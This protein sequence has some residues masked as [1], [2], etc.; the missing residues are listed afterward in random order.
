MENPTA[1][2]EI[3]NSAIKFV[4][5]YVID[6]KASIIYKKSIP[7]RD[8]LRNGDIDDYSG[9]TNAI[10]VFKQIADP[11]CKLR[12]QVKDVTLIYPAIGFEVYST[13]KSTNLVSA[14]NIVQKLDITNAISL[15]QKEGVPNGSIVID[16]IPSVFFLDENRTS[17][18]PP[19]GAKSTS[20]G[21]RA[22]VHTL[23]L[24][25]VN[26]YN[27]VVQSNEINIKRGFV[28][29]YAIAE[30]IKHDLPDVKNYMLLDL[31]EDIANVS[32]IGN[33]FPYDSSYIEAGADGLRRK[34]SETFSIEPDIA[35]ELIERYGLSNRDI[36]FSPKLVDKQGK[37]L[38]FTERE[39]SRVIEEYLDKYFETLKTPVEQ[40]YQKYAKARVFPLILTG[41]FSKLNGID[42]YLKKAFPENDIVFYVPKALGARD[43]GFAS[44]VGALYLSNKYRGS[45][46]D[47][48]SKVGKLSRES[49]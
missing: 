47:Q 3:S 13:D 34:I 43:A 12:L 32:L 25:L 40:I 20:I 19:I 49:K 5:G 15:V 22:F 38:P 37:E 45:L 6:D 29:S 4:A 24:R 44:L 11:T 14:S 27:R 35:E 36:K 17:G 46:T 9:L 26:E 2:I 18:V 41:G 39:L 28:S 31:G 1:I 21:I 16:I 23:P 48:T 10:G 42:R 30:S 33:Y 8:F 7:A